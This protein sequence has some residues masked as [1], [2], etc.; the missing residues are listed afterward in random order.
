[1]AI[2]LFQ[3]VAAGVAVEQA[4]GL[5]EVVGQVLGQRDVLEAHAEQALARVAEDLAEPPVDAQKTPIRRDVRDAHRGHLEGRAQPLLALAQ[6]LLG[7]AALRLEA[8]RTDDR[9]DAREQR[10]EHLHQCVVGSARPVRQANHAD[11]LAAVKQGHAEKRL[12]RCVA[13]RQAAAAR[14]VRRVVGDHRHALLDRRAEQRVEVVELERRVTAPVLVEA[15]PRRVVPADVGQHI[16]TQEAMAVG[17]IVEHLADE[18]VFAAGDAQQV[19]QQRVED[20]AGRCRTDEA[21]L[22]P[23]DDRAEI[24]MS[25]GRR[26]RI[27]QGVDCLPGGRFFNVTHRPLTAHPSGLTGASGCA[28]C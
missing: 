9:A 20:F 26:W 15:L 24:G 17:R 28:A 2:A 23:A 21:R 27:A 10:L 8:H 12:H 18:A 1:M 13:R 6:R 19:D 7:V 4:L 14:I 16:N 11:H 25:R 22:H 5:L 3:R